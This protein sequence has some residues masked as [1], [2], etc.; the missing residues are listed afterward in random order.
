MVICIIETLKLRKKNKLL[1]YKE[2]TKNYIYI[3]IFVVLATILFSAFW[4]I[5]N[6]ENKLIVTHKLKS[7][8]ENE[9][10]RIYFLWNKSVRFETPDLIGYK[11]IKDYVNGLNNPEYYFVSSL[12]KK[13]N[14]G[15][16]KTL[17]LNS[18]Q[19]NI[20]FPSVVMIPR[21]KTSGIM[22]NGIPFYVSRFP[23][24]NWI[25]RD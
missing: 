2:M 18:P 17:Q 24:L 6:P 12:E 4:R 3:I 23:L 10:T 16:I 1:K 14:E 11:F 25:L 21:G 13:D 19:L 5:K 15:A 22:Y 8:S 7:P 9:V 20:K